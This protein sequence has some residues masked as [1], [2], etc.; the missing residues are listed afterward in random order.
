[1]EGNPSAGESGARWASVDEQL[2]AA[3]ATHGSAF[4]AFIRANQEY[5]LLRPGE[6]PNDGV[7]VPLWL[8]VYYRK[9]HPDEPPAPA[10]PIGDYPEVLHRIEEWMEANQDLSPDPARWLEASKGV[11]RG[12]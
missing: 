2:A 9:Q 3:K 6:G 5:D 7:G 10:G 4:E 8:R 12:N 11:Q 1:M